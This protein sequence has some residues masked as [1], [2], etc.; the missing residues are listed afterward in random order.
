MKQSKEK[1]EA[2]KRKTKTVYYMLYIGD[3]AVRC[4]VLDFFF[5]FERATVEVVALEKMGSLPVT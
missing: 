4:R 1:R 3:R 2:I 5:L